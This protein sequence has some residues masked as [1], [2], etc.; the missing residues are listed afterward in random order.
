M[1]QSWDEVLEDEIMDIVCEGCQEIGG[2]EDPCDTC[3]GDK[4]VNEIRELVIA[5]VIEFVE[6]LE[7]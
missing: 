5:P 4:L 3:P 7:D 6:N 2:D 1:G